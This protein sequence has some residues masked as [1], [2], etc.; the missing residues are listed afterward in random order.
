MDRYQNQLRAASQCLRDGRVRDA[1]SLC[2]QVLRASPEH[3]GA[4]QLLATLAYQAGRA[5]DAAELFGRALAKRPRDAALLANIGLARHAAGDRAAAIEHFREALKLNARCLQTHVNLSNALR[6]EGDLTAAE[7]HC[8][9]AL[10][11][12]DRSPEAHNNLGAVLQERG[13]LEAAEAAFRNAVRYRPNYAQAHFN[14]GFVLQK[15]RRYEQ[16]LD[17]YRRAARIQPNYAQALN[18]LGNTLRSLGRDREAIEAYRRALAAKPNHLLALCNLAA[19]LAESDR[20]EE[21]FRLLDRALE[22]EPNFAEFHHV[23]GQAFQRAERFEEA[24]GAYRRSVALQPDNATAWGNLAVTCRSMENLE[25]AAAAYRD[26]CRLEPD[27]PVWRLREATLWPTIFEDNAQ[28]DRHVE[29]FRE[30][31]EAMARSGATFDPDELIVS[32]AEPPFGLQFAAGDLRA[33]KERYAELFADVFADEPP[34]PNRG[35]PRI[36]IVVSDGHEKPLAISMRGVLKALQGGDFDFTI[37]C[38]ERGTDRLRQQMADVPVAYLPLA[39]PLSHIAR[40]IREARFDV[41]FHHEIGTGPL[42]YFLPFYRL[43]PV[44]C[45]C[46]AIQVT[47]GNPRVDFYLSSRLV[48]PDDAHDHYTEELLLADTMLPYRYR[49]VCE[50]APDTRL[51]F[52]LAD[53]EHLYVCAHQLG[54][55]HPDFDPWL[56]SILL[57]DPRGRLVLI[58]DKFGYAAKALEQ[59]FRRTL[60]EC[61]N[62]VTIL[63]RLEHRDYLALLGVSDVLLDPPHFGGMNTT[64]DGLSLGK[65][66]VTLPSRYHRGRYTLGC[67]RRMGVDD[68]IARDPAEY[69][70]LAVGLASDRQ[71]R[72]RLEGRLIEASNELFED[73]R[74][75][76]EHRRLFEQMVAAA[77]NRP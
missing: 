11:I 77:R 2:R 16:A 67:Y 75:I 54:K 43:A 20:G 74:A 25:E 48:E 31:T 33:V 57:R 9:T 58:A 35:K 51:R 12:N 46:Y 15:T 26:A 18:N 61:F 60:A 21:A 73:Q 59:R 44:Q 40:R 3:P 37:V 34:P 6:E 41:V 10:K 63:P 49:E 70:E 22:A 28:I 56:R 39:G 50:R 66:I 38:S 53:E 17:H 36:G 45:T 42:N 1:E 64:Y 5:A 71:E 30:S 76:D 13:K 69:V 52:G 65:P 7:T 23:L 8:R 68:C 62:R 47:S 24:V 29:Q 32:G 14:L 27:S 55:C 19:A 4:L 72:R